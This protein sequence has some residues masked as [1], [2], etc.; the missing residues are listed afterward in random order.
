MIF[1][2]IQFPTFQVQGQTIKQPT[3]VV[4]DLRYARN[5]A[6]VYVMLSRAQSLSQIYI[7]NN[8]YEEKWRASRS[9]LKEFDLGLENAINVDKQD[10]EKQFEILSLNVL[11]LRKH[12]QDLQDMSDQIV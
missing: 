2:Y 5:E 9:G 12:I 10:E 6:Q 11:S 4:V 8:L 3:S 1:F 7:I